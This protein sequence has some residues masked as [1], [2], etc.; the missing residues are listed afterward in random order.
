V[1]SA[2]NEFAGQIEEEIE[3]RGNVIRAA[4]IKGQGAA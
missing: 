4:R 1:V 2:A 3:T